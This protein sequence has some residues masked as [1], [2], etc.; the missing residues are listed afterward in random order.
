LKTAS[1][2]QKHPPAKTAFCALAGWTD[3]DWD[4]LFG[5]DESAQMGVTAVKTNAAIAIRLVN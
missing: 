1:T 3:D 2:P 4:L 5:R